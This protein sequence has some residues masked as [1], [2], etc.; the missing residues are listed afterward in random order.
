MVG[1]VGAACVSDVIKKEFDLIKEEPGGLGRV[2]LLLFELNYV[3]Y[4]FM[5]LPKQSHYKQTYEVLVPYLLAELVWR[6][7]SQVSK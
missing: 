6:L 4:M 3:K 5:H 7:Y 2:L 1:K